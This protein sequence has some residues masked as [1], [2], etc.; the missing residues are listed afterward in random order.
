[1]ND[2]DRVRGMTRDHRGIRQLT[3]D[4]VRDGRDARREK[5]NRGEKTREPRMRKPD[6][7]ASGG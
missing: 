7:A 5:L 4:T 6:K 1:M 3:V 2:K